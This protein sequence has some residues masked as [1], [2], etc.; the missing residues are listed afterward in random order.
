M[1]QRSMPW[2]STTPGDAGPYSAADWTRIWRNIIGVAAGAGASAD[3]GILWGSGNAP[4]PGLSVT[5]NSPTGQSV[6]VT[7]GMALV[8]GTFYYSD[9][10][11]VLAVAANGSGNPRVDTVVLRKDF[12]AQTVRLAVKQGTPAATPVPPGM[13]QNASTWEIPIAD[14][15][16]ANGFLTI[17]TALIAQRFLY[18][19]VAEMDV[20]DNVINAS[21]V[22]VV[23]GDVMVWGGTAG[24]V[25]SNATRG[26][27]VAGIAM[28]RAVNGAYVRLLRRGF[29]YV[30]LNTI[31]ASIGSYVI[32]DANFVGQIPAAGSS[33]WNA[34]ALTREIT[35]AAGLTLC[36]VDVTQPKPKAL[37]SSTYSP[38]SD[39][40][41]STT[42]YA[43]VDATNLTATIITNT[44]NVRA[45]FIVPVE[46]SHTAGS[47]WMCMNIRRDGT[48]LAVNDAR[49]LRTGNPV[50]NFGTAGN[51]VETWIVEY[52]FKGLT[53]GSHSFVLEWV[54][55]L[56]T[57]TTPVMTLR[58]GTGLGGMI[59]RIELEEMD[60]S[61]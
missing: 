29:A 57:A 47:A 19:N 37:I 9:A 34:F 3:S 53:P 40:S 20:I 55:I 17:T 27:P 59:S 8:N 44:G 25:T 21:G 45:R 28:N 48:T 24:Q 26:I 58:S 49:G 18:A 10:N 22:T 13:T 1:T 14:L 61:V 46:F 42:T 4:D 12:A 54:A 11:V 32:H 51:Y 30:R 23:A 39:I 5:Q 36:Y 16:L 50:S 35:A 15:T 41:S 2:T 43:A 60:A 6:I 38:P 33:L 31:S 7:P 56:G 52:T